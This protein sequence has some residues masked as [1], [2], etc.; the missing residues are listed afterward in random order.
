MFLCII[1]I[2][3]VALATSRTWGPLRQQDPAFPKDTL[4]VTGLWEGPR[5][6]K[7]GERSHNVGYQSPKPIYIEG[8]P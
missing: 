5:L 1:N 4:L 6:R 7:N 2:L 3:L 8:F